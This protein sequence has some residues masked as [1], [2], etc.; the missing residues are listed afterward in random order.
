MTPNLKEELRGILDGIKDP[1]VDDNELNEVTMDSLVQLGIT[2]FQAKKTILGLKVSDYS[3]GPEK[4][5]TVDGQ[6]IWTFNTQL[7]DVQVYIK[8]SD[9]FDGIQAKC[10]SFHKAEFKMKKPFNGSKK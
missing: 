4:D 2:P 1:I 8:L 7:N 5:H 6:N 10:I 3:S 9:N